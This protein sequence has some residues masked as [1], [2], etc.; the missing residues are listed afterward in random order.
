MDVEQKFALLA[1][2]ATFEPSEEV[3]SVPPVPYSIESTVNSALNLP[4]CHTANPRPTTPL[5]FGDPR[6][7]EHKDR[8]GAAARPHS[9][10]TGQDPKDISNSVHMAAMPGGKRLPMLKTMLTSACERDCYYCPFRAGRDFRRATFK[11]DEMASA[12]DQIVRKGIAQG[13]FLSSGIAG[14]GPRTQ[15]KLIAAVEILRQKHEFAGYVH[16]K[17]MPGAEEDQI[18]RAMQ[19]ANRVSINLEAPNT[20]RL[21]RIAPHKLMIDELVR[22]LR[23]VEKIRRENGGRGP[24]QVT[25]FVVGGADESDAEILKT[26]AYLHREVRLARAY[27]SAFRPLRDTPLEN[28]RPTDPLREHRL[29]QADFLLR[30]YS[31]TFDDFTFDDAGN[32]PLQADPK[33]AWAQAHLAHA[34]VDL[35]RATREELLRVPGLGPKSVE[36]ILAAR[37]QGRLR[38]LGHLRQLNILAE[39]AAPYILLDGKRP[40]HQ[41]TLFG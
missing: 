14:G 25:Q 36:T 22:P 9:R 26:V 27:F 28:H 33:A 8:A 10:P 34:P 2:N 32:L 3:P 35:N 13:L 40:A 30:Q 21:A 37:R 7:V 12:V 15:D 4:S 18:R 38:D 19:I 23:I 17:L 20:E 16:L 29:Y 41:L 39:R 24:S 11:P 1:D 5:V 6:N 31:F